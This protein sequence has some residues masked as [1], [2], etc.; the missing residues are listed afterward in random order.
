MPKV[1]KKHITVYEHQK[2][3]VGEGLSQDQY[4]ALLRFYGNYSPFFT[5]IRNGVK[6]CSYVGVLQVG[7]TLIEILP[8]AD[9]SSGKGQETLWQKVLIQMLRTVWGFSVREAGSSALKVKHHSV[10]DLYFELYLC[11]VEKLVH[12]GLIKKYRREEQNTVTMKGKL[13]FTKHLQKN[14]VHQ[15]R[16]YIETSNYTPQHLLHQVLFAALQVVQNLNRNTLLHARIG[17]LLLN[18]P[19]QKPIQVTP[20]TFERLPQDR[21]SLLYGPALEIAELLLLNYHPDIRQGRKHVLALM[22][23]MNALWEQF[24]LRLLQRNMKSYTVS[25][26]VNKKFWKSTAGSL[27]SSLRP[28]ILI[29]GNYSTVVL[30]TK[31]KNLNG[32]GPSADDLRQMYVYHEYFH[33]DLVALLYPGTDR[34]LSGA[35]FQKVE[36]KRLDTKQC[37]I[38]QIGVEENTT[39]WQKKIVAAVEEL[40]QNSP[41]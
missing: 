29:R 12:A 32:E 37:H 25:G 26:Q 40:F 5:L 28:D 6:F 3:M 14:L 27:S 11:E 23:D 30:D 33:A 39:L 13:A 17:R 19:E 7:N 38:I 21:K 9:M 10:L 15:E 36:N 2:L 41:N 24:V 35:Y 8:K 18:F 1:E 34:K 22:F 31:W 20:G 4:E 16:F